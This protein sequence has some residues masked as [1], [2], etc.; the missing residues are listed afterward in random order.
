MF[1]VDLLVGHLAHLS[2]IQR[3]RKL[4]LQ[5]WEEQK[6]RNIAIEMNVVHES[7]DNDIF[8]SFENKSIV[9]P[10][11]ILNNIGT[12]G[13]R[14]EAAP[15]FARKFPILVREPHTSQRLLGSLFGNYQVARSFLYTSALGAILESMS[16]LV[17]ALQQPNTNG[18]F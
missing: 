18:G 7:N 10:P 4:K 2:L 5:A 14:R 16:L 17:V 9:K 1:V 6:E 8:N 13:T 15:T 3:M 11:E 12:F